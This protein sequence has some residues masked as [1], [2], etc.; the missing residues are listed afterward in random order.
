MDA[1]E[2]TLLTVALVGLALLFGTLFY[3][4]NR[5]FKEEVKAKQAQHKY[6]METCKTVNGNILILNDG[7]AYCSKN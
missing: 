6:T 4:S 2:K 7:S 1:T 5:E 3:V